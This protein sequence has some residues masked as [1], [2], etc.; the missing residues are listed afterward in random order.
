M[1]Y[2][3]ILSEIYAHHTKRMKTSLWGIVFLLCLVSLLSA[4]ELCYYGGELFPSASEPFPNHPQGPVK[5]RTQSDALPLV[6]RAVYQNRTGAAILSGHWPSGMEALLTE[7]V[8]ASVQVLLT[9]RAANFFPRNLLRVAFLAVN[10]TLILVSVFGASLTTSIG[11]L[12][13]SSEHF[14]PRSS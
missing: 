5:V 14:W 10:L 1:F 11:Y 9:F 8:C 3:Y 12:C 13:M 2:D 4:E 7:L 6:L